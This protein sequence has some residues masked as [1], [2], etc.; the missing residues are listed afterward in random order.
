MGYNISNEAGMKMTRNKRR[1]KVGLIK[2]YTWITIIL[3]LITFFVPTALG[4]QYKY[5]NLHRLTRV[6]YNDGMQITYNYDEVGNR[7][8]RVSTLM[9]DTS[10]DGTVNFKDFAILA[11]RWLE[12]GCIS[13]DWC[14][15]AD[16]D[17]NTEVGIEDLAILA[18]Q[19][20]ESINP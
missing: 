15:G 19:W 2:R 11:S 17:W 18:D 13:P 9:A 12:E 7:T 16:I 1:L 8:Q 20:L 4:T 14:Q 10:V 3:V 5:D 6:I